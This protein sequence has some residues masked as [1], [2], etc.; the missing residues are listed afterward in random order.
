MHQASECEFCRISLRKE[1]ARAI[2]E[3]PMALA[4]F[5]LQPAILG[6][7]LVIPTQHVP[8]LW[9]VDEPLAN[10]LLHVA[11][12]ISHAIRVAMNPDGLN[13]ITSAGEAASQTIFHLHLHVV[14]RW[15][16]DRIGNIWPPKTDYDNAIKDEIANRIRHACEGSMAS[17]DNC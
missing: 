16:H 1:T 10:H 11:I 6:H 4:F 14:P 15:Y 7:T 17:R 3:T 13:L 2:C 5:P 8:D 9:S 12:R